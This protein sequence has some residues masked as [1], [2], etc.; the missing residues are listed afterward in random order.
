MND[1]LSKPVGVHELGALFARLF[2]VPAAP[3][4]PAA[5]PAVNDDDLF[6]RSV[7]VD[8]RAVMS[9]ER[10]V[11]LLATFF[12]DAGQLSARMHDALRR[13]AIDD[14]RQ[15]AHGA[16]GAALNLGLKALADAAQQIHRGSPS[17]AEPLA[18]FDDLL[19]RTRL[20][21]TREGLL[22]AAAA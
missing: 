16:R 18:R 2:G 14:A 10:F 1:F 9:H 22:A 21:C 12:A 13:G 7:M 4:V 11:T 19:A 3:S 20:A 6:D 8:V 17:I 15:A 5:A